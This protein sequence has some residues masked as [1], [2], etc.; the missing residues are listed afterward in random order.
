MTYYLHP[1]IPCPTIRDA[2][3]VPAYM[4]VL[5]TV[6]NG[7]MD[8]SREYFREKSAALAYWRQVARRTGY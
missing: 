3:G 4:V 7:I 8:E 5:V 1:F 6:H 2:E